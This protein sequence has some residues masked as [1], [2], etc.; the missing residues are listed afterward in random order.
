MRKD[1]GRQSAICVFALALR[2]NGGRTT[3]SSKS[4]SQLMAAYPTLGRAVALAG[5][6]RAQLEGWLA[7]ARRSRLTPFR[8]LARTI[9][10]HFDGLLGLH[11]DQTD[12]RCPEGHKRL[13]T[14]GLT[15]CPRIPQRPLLPTRRLPQSRRGHPSGSSFVTH[16]KRQR[17]VLPHLSLRLLALPTEV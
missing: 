3:A 10:R 9:K 7:S 13:V 5:S 16:L 8:D 14:I 4:P 1:L 2:S 6:N 17:D 15:P 12:Q 11:G